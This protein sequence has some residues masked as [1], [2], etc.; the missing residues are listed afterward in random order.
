MRLIQF[1][2]AFRIFL[3]KATGPWFTVLSNGNGDGNLKVTITSKLGYYHLDDVW[4]VEI[5]VQKYTLWKKVFGIGE[6]I[7]P[8]S[9]R[10]WEILPFMLVKLRL[11]YPDPQIKRLKRTNAHTSWCY[12]RAPSSSDTIHN[13]SFGLK[14]FAKVDFFIQ[15]MRFLTWT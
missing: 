11:V 2:H 4:F 10:W 7:V 3:A 1:S 9:L 12:W 8:F 5:L 13:L 6:K 14:S 15:N